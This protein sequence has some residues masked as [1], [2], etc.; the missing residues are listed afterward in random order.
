MKKKTKKIFLEDA[1]LNE[2]WLQ[3][4]IENDP[5]I[6]GLG[7]LTTNNR[8]FRKDYQDYNHNL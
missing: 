7:D 8:K 2:T 3:N 4:Q 5:S 6:L 1:G